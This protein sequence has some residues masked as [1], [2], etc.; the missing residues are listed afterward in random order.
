MDKR[1]VELRRCFRVGVLTTHMLGTGKAC[2]PAAWMRSSLM[3]SFADVRA[4]LGEA[5]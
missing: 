4:L 2:Q 1:T 3:E 5:A